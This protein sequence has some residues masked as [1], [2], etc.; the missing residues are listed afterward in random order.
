MLVFRRKAGRTR[1]F[2]CITEKQSRKRMIVRPGQRKIRHGPKRFR[3]RKFIL[4]RSIRMRMA[5]RLFGIGTAEPTWWVE[6]TREPRA[7][8][9]KNRRKNPIGKPST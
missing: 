1:N 4:T 3:V 6:R 7:A 8:T 2:G 5:T 9:Q